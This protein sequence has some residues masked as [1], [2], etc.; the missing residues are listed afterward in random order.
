MRAAIISIGDEILIGQV[1][2][3]NAAFIAQKVSPLGISVSKI[4]V[5]G[6]NEEDIIS[7]LETEYLCHDILFVTGG[8]GPTHDDI[9]RSAICKF[10]RTN[11]VSSADARKY[12]EEF[13][14]QRNRPWSEA[15]ENQ[16][17]I[18]DGAKPIP[19]KFGTAA[20]EFFDCDGKY[21]I[22]MPGVPYEMESM[23]TDFVIPYFQNISQTYFIIHRTLMT[24][25]IPESELATRLGDLNQM[26]QGA[27]LAFLP[28]P[29]GV[30]LRITVEGKDSDE[31]NRLIKTIESD[32]RQKA[33]KYIYGVDDESLEEAL[34][35][36][37]IERK[38]T[39]SIAESCTGGLIANKLT[40]VSGSS[41]YIERA[42][43]T[44][45]NKS[46]IEM[47]SIPEKL[48]STHG[49]V[50]REVAEEMARSIRNL[51]CTDIGIST[52]GIAGPTGGT[53]DK[54]IGLVWI[55]YSDSN[56]TIAL[57]FNFGEG[58]LRVKERATQAAMD[59]IRRKIMKIK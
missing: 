25:G 45:S 17:L 5:A 11:L 31:S 49:A 35:K 12:V 47:L 51:S 26:L 19:N 57:R 9:T 7:A 6:D 24:T 28:S 41:K 54:L 27:K 36:L 46:K 1:I 29:A 58:R 53:P 13:L 2:N 48:I 21:V 50:S 39:L 52:T 10:F 37:M 59:L 40:N 32:I 15:A 3:T 44:Y 34:G 16:T 23:I 20:G 18:P 14:R 8:L 55:G 33:E 42:V 43:V 56:E 22:V 30:R 4:I 38:L